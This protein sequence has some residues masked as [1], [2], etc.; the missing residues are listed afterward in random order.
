MQDRITIGTV[1][2]RGPGARAAGLPAQA[3]RELAGA[4]WPLAPRAQ[5]FIR[6]LRVRGRP[7]ELGRL[8]AARLAET[9]AGA[10]GPEVVRFADRAALAA[11]LS[12]DLLAGTAARRWWWA[13]HQDLVALPPGVALAQL[14]S[15]HAEDLVAV[16]AALARQARLEAAFAALGAPGCWAVAAALAQRLATPLPLQ[17]A[18]ARPPSA[19]AERLPAAIDRRWRPLLG[20]AGVPAPACWLAGVLALLEAQPLRLAGA[21]GPAAVAALI[22]AAAPAVRLG[23][24]FVPAAP[25]TA[26]AGAGPGEAVPAASA[27]AAPGPDPGRRAAGDGPLRPAGLPAAV[28][29][30]PATAHPGQE[31]A[32]PSPRT[33]AGGADAVRCDAEI[34]ASGYVG[35]VV[36]I[37]LLRV[38]ALAQVAAERGLLARRGSAWRLLAALA[39]ALGLP[40]DDALALWL[41]RTAA[42]LE[43]PPLAEDAAR[44]F[45]AAAAALLGPRL[46]APELIAVA[47]TLVATPTHLDAHLPLA[48]VRVALRLA[49]LDVDPGWVPWLGRVVAIHYHAAAAADQGTP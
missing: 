49:G 32:A 14:W 19:P 37:N 44:A 25:A 27:P 35:A 28:R 18:A 43:E 30:A 22:A 29:T 1:R 26:D 11:A 6:R 34:I 31:P 20:A 16:C 23:R 3:R 15:R 13:S 39:A 12:L 33:P 21:A 45:I 8:A 47:G 36:L 5:V 10:D 46:W 9:L 17:V 40:A 24:S 41:E 2:L 38:P 48:A 7:G 4:P 42:A